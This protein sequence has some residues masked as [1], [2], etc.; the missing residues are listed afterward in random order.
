MPSRSFRIA[1]I[2]VSGLEMIAKILKVHRVED[3]YCNEFGRV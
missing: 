2:F 1:Q 3:V